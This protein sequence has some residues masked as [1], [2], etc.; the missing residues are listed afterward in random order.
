MFSFR[1]GGILDDIFT[2]IMFFFE[3]IVMP[4]VLNPQGR[5]TKL[6]VEIGSGQS[7]VTSPCLQ[8]E[9]NSDNFFYYKCG[10]R[11]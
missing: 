10:R 4:L 1:L 9:S 11:I 3:F 6:K 8:Y 2:V 7:R 5:K